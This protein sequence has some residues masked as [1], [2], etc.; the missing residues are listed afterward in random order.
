MKSNQKGITLLGFLITL[1]V[2]GIFI[3][4][5]IR[6][7]PVYSEYYAV[8]ESMD[9][10]AKQPGIGSASR[11]DIEKFLDARFNISYV[12]SVN[13]KDHVRLTRTAAGQDLNINYEVRKPFAYN[14]DFV[15]KFEYTVSL[16]V[17]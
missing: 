6:L 14:V 17:R 12:D 5:G 9:A 3:F 10:I 2:V 15:A 16:K 1:V 7:F 4:V 11:R 8:R 13:I